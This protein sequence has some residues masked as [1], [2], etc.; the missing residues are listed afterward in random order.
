VDV[1][2]AGLGRRANFLV[3]AIVLAALVAAAILTIRLFMTT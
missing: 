3:G 2:K 1:F